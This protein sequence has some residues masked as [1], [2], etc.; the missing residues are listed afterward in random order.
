MKKQNVAF[1]VDNSVLYN[2]VGVRRYVISLANALR[3][4]FNV[5]IFNIEYE[6]TNLKPYYTELF[7]DIEFAQDNGFSTNHLVGTNKQVILRE[8]KKVFLAVKK[9]SEPAL[10]LCKCSYGTQLPTDLDIIVFSAPWVLK[11]EMSLCASK[12]VFCIAYDTIPNHYSL[13]SPDNKVLRTFAY[14]H[15]FAYKTFLSKYDGLLAISN[16]SAC[17]LVLMFPQFENKIYAA[18]PFLP[19]G[20]ET[21][22]KTTG[23][24]VSVV[25]E[26][27][28]LLASPLDI[29]KGLKI[30]PGYINKLKM[31]RLIIFG[32][33]RCSYREASEF[34]EQLSMHDITWWSEVN[35]FKQVELYEA[36]KLVLFPSLHE[37]LGL[38]VLESYCCGTPVY[39]SNI[40][41]LNQLVSKEFVL[42]NEIEKNLPAM[43]ATIDANRDGEQF[44]AFALKNWASDNIVNFVK[45][46]AKDSRIRANAGEKCA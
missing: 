35:F 46:L 8:L 21:K 4:G 27:V 10:G 32:S 36:S 44:K 33:P 2:H 29:R 40:P 20:F 5:R 18:P 45:E 42:S 26:K 25:E 38:P 11:G 24:S 41:P 6:P 39:D 13:V 12:G 43:Q 19:T 9:E 31:D 3:Q 1:I 14:Q 22:A 34:F 17:Q 37:G 7:I 30:L 23:V 15:L 28:V 16:E